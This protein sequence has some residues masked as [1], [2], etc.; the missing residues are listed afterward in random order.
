AH[1]WVFGL[2]V[3]LPFG[4]FYQ[5]GVFRSL[6]HFGSAM[7]FN[8]SL[9]WLLRG[10]TGSIQVGAAICGV[11]FVAVYTWGVV[12]LHPAKERSADPALG[13]LFSLTALILLSPT[14]HFWYL[15]WFVPFFIVR[16]AWAWLVPLLT[17]ALSLQAVHVQFHTGVWDMSPLL[18]LAEWLPV[19]LALAWSAKF[20]MGRLR[21]SIPVTEAITGKGGVSVIVP[22]LNEGS[23]I[24]ECVHAIRKD[25]VVVEVIVVD[26]GSTDLT[27]ELAS[28]AGCAVF[29]HTA[30]IGQG[31]GRGGQ[32]AEGIDAAQWDV[33][34]V[35]HA[36][37][38]PHPRAFSSIVE[39]LR[40]N[41]D[42]VGGVAG[43]GFTGKNFSTALVAKANDLRAWLF[44]IGFGDQIQFAR[45][46]AALA[47]QLMARIPLMEDV[48]FSLRMAKIGKSDMLWQDNAVSNRSWLKKP[49]GR[50]GLILGLFFSYLLRRARGK[51]DTSAMF[52]RYYS[53]KPENSS[54]A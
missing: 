25:P 9:H 10:I 14:V 54:G 46:D 42:C 45:R 47:H 22:T 50:A 16:R 17:I 15:S 23:E 39:H 13:M 31:G 27:R 53:T 20:A 11:L 2:A 5:D 26:G 33:V 30:P 38:R 32:I 52:A 44:G 41:P 3:I 19:W 51:V 24:S 18:G 8:G 4:P 29:E 43:S 28:Q 36:D 49:L 12:N 34:A 7:A 40:L 37:C 6:F 35:V 1:S 48:E 21:S